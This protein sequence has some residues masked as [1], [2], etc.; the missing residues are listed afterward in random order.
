VYIPSAILDDFGGETMYNASMFF[1]FFESRKD[2]RNAPLS[3]YLGG[4]PGSTSLGG[5]TAENGPCYINSDS[6]STTLNPW[7]WNNKVNMLY[8]DQPV[9]VGFSYDKLVPSILDLL[10]GAIAP[11]N[12]LETSNSTTV[13]GILPSQDPGSAANTTGNAAK[14]LWQFTQIWLQ[15]FPEHESSDNRI[16]LW[17][18]SVGLLLLLTH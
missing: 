10:T 14:I 11:D 18:N 16:S 2:P 8:I 1:W 12:G 13:T 4:G 9:Q 5:A 6:N 7:S 3:L 17:A 15:D